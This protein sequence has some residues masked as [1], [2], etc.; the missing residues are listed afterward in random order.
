MLEHG[1]ALRAAVAHY[2]LPLDNW[3]DLSTGINPNGWPVPPMIPPAVWQRLPEP[4]DGLETA[5][6]AYY[7]TPHL[8]PVAGSQAAIQALPLLRKPGRVGVLNPSYAEHAYA[9]Q[10]NGHR[11]ELL[12]V[13]ALNAA[14]DRLDVLA[15][16]HPNNPTAAR[17][18][19]NLLLDWRARLAARGGWLIVDEAFMDATPAESLA[20]YTGSPGL[21]VLR[22][23]GKFF[24]LAGV[25]VGFVL[26]E[27]AVLESLQEQLGPW[28]LSGPSRWVATQALVD[29]DGQEKM[30][31]GLGRLSGRLAELLKR[32]RL[33]V[34]DGTAL[35]QWVPTPDAEFW[36]D[37]LARRG[38]LV[39]R[40]ADPPGL[41]FGL[42]GSEPAWRRLEMALA[43]VRAERLC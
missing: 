19:L 37:A 32:Q 4:D 31:A 35:F 24:G 39:R 2:G 41:R 33:P 30:R 13:E 42:P 25:R 11:V 22:S 17:F 9:W 7:G 27:P 21:I 14:I 16:V 40:F 12:P 5:A 20:G 28:S 3:L 23:L 34:A 1:G 36:Q 18:P 26:A 38:I 15:L 29:S 10:R 6:A 43:G 8:L